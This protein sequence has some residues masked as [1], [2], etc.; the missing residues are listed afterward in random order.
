MTSHALKQTHQDLDVQMQIFDK[1][2]RSANTSGYAQ[3]MHATI[4]SLASSRLEKCF[5]TLKR[6]Y[7]SR[8]DIEPLL[9]AIKSSLNHE[10]PVYSSMAELEQ[11]TSNTNN[12][13][14]TSLRHTIQQLTQWASATALLNP[15][16]YTH[17]QIYTSI[18]VLGA[19][20]TLRAIIDEVK[21]QTEAGFGAAALDIGVSIICAP[22]VEDSV[23]PSA[24]TPI[25]PPRTHMNLREMLKAEYDNA[26]SIM[27][28]DPSAAETTVRLHRRVEAQLLSMSQTSISATQLDIPHVSMINLPTQSAEL[29]KA[30]ND[31][32]SAAASMA[33]AGGELDQANQQALQQTLDLDLSAAGGALDLSGINVEVPGT[34][35]MSAAM[36]NLPDLGDLGGMGMDLGEDDDA[37]GLD[38]DNM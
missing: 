22:T 29:D 27:V 36:E 14:Y 7:P 5:R 35:D 13:L 38:F 17:R 28:T 19:S 23:I 30:L 3:T 21:T 10:R 16:S 9:Q 6:R 20:R 33:A 37:W 18:K 15:P 34:G 31:A 4:L 12:T 2:I 24:M 8:T 11:W 26:A 32:A 25:P 1:L